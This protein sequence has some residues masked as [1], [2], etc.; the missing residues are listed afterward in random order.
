MKRFYYILSGLLLLPLQSSAQAD[1][2]EYTPLVGIPGIDNPGDINTQTYIN[3]LYI[4]AIS[5]AAFLAVGRLLLAGLKYIMSDVVTTKED[6]K[7][8]IKGA[9]IGLGIVLTA[10]LILQTINPQL[11]NLDILRNATTTAINIAP[12]GQAVTTGGNINGGGNDPYCRDGSLITTLEGSVCCRNNSVDPACYQD[13]A[14]API[15]AVSESETAAGAKVYTGIWR[16]HEPALPEYDI[17]AGDY[18][19]RII[20][21]L[22]QTTTSGISVAFTN[23]TSDTAATTDNSGMYYATLDDGGILTIGECLVTPPPPESSC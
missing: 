17:P 19:G 6:A 14:R 5:I 21:R 15:G 1:S 4:L 12:Y 16:V 11:T 9:F 2:T 23:D 20:T 22:E 8:D 13:A 18:H 10:T 3:S 7:K